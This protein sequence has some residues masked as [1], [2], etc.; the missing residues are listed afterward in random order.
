VDKVV[1]VYEEPE[2]QVDIEVAREDEIEGF[3][4]FL[5][6]TGQPVGKK[7]A[8]VSADGWRRYSKLQRCCLE[9]GQC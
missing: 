8:D 5:R 7:P 3:V 2:Y 4:S 1:V 6:G 9:G